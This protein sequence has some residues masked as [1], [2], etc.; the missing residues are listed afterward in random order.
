MKACT[1]V[2]GLPDAWKVAEHTHT[3]THTHIHTDTHTQTHTSHTLTLSLTHTHT[4]TR[5]QT[6]I[7]KHTDTHTHTHTQVLGTLAA[8]TLVRGVPDAWN[9]A[10]SYAST[11]VGG[12]AHCPTRKTER[13]R[14]SER[15]SSL[16]I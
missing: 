9:V 5:T 14:D 7:H 4:Q 8:C 1:L 2:R 3:C 12:C 10:A 13:T 15:E 6:H 11:Y 16:N